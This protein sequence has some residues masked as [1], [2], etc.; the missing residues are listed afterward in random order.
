MVNVYKDNGY[1][2][3]SHYLASLAMEYD[4][5]ISNILSLADVMGENEDFDGLVAMLDDN[6]G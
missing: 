4:V 6:L 2:N 1:E 5:D 3:R